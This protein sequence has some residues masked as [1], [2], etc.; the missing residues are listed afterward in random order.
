MKNLSNGKVSYIKYI[1]TLSLISFAAA[2]KRKTK[3]ET[4]GTKS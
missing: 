1:V 2:R 3:E 4:K